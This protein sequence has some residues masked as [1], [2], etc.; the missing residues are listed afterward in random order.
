MTARPDLAALVCSICGD[1]PAQILIADPTAGLDTLCPDCW[2]ARTAEAP[3]RVLD[4]AAYEDDAGQQT[5][6]LIALALVDAMLDN[7]PDRALML[8]PGPYAVDL[9]NVI[10]P[11]TKVAV[12]AIRSLVGW[13]PAA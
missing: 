2:Q 7:D 11:L 3:P 9:V 12:A 10:H 5:L 13:E 8:L 4:P 6:K 1:G